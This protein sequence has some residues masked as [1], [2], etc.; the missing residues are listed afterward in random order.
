VT[1]KPFNCVVLADRH[2]GLTEGVRGLLETMFETVV[3]VADETS[4][5]ESADRLRPQMAVVDMSLGRE[6]GLHWLRE[7]HDRCPLVKLIVLSVHD[8]P[9]VRRA[10]AEAG[11]DGFVLKRAIGT[12]LLRTAES[13]LAGPAG[14]A[15]T[16][17]V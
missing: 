4:L 17:G 10:A 9:T 14:A 2:L 1:E 5:L 8:E 12:D 7:L 6:S 15:P 16:G 13:L 11:A 3:M